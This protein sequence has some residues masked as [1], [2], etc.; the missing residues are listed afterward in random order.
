MT[1]TKSQ[2]IQGHSL[3]DEKYPGLLPFSDKTVKSN[4]SG[5]WKPKT[6]TWEEFQKIFINGRNT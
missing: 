3:R 4:L 2:N 6:Y 1:K 5:G